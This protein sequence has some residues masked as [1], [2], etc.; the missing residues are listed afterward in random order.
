MIAANGKFFTIGELLY[1]IHN[2]VCDNLENDD[3]VYFEGLDLWEGEHPNYPN[4]P[5]YFLQQGS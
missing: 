4:I 3:H 2:V 5:L 1:K